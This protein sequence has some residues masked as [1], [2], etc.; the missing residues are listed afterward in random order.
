MILTA[1]HAHA[2]GH[3]D[4]PGPGKNFNK[5]FCCIDMSMLHFGEAHSP[6]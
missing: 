4:G 1:T 6:K 3:L 5:V 2:H